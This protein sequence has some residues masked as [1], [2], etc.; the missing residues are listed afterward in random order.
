MTL[1]KKRPDVNYILINAFLTSAYFISAKLGLL[2]AV[3]VEQ[4]TLFWPP[5]GISLAFLLIFG[6]KYWPGFFIGAFFANVLTS[7]P[8]GV[9]LIIAIGNTLEALVG[10]YLLERFN[11]NKSFV[12]LTDFIRFII[13]GVIVST[14]IS[15]TVGVT[16][17]WLVGL[18]Q[19]DDIIRIFGIWWLGDAIGDLIFASLILILFSEKKLFWSF[20]KGIEF[21]LIIIATT[22]ISIL[23]FLSQSII[24]ILFPFFVLGAIRFKKLGSVALALIISV[25]SVWGTFFQQSGPFYIP[26]NLELSLLHL[27]LFVGIV[28]ATYLGLAI[29]IQENAEARDRLQD[30]NTDLRKF[31]LAVAYAS[32]HI[33]ITDADGKILYA[34]RAAVKTTGYST[35]E[36]LGKNPSLWGG[37]MPD[38]F[39]EKMW[40]VIKNNKKT[41]RAEVINKRKNGILYSSAIGISPV[42]DSIGNIAFYVG[43]ERDIT[44]EKEIDRMKTEFISLASHQLRT[45]LGI[46][47]WYLEMLL[48]GDYGKIP[49]RIR[50]VVHDIYKVNNRLITLVNNLLSVSRIQEGKPLNKPTETN[51]INLIKE[52]ISRIKPE[53][54]KYGLQMRL[55]LHKSKVKFPLIKIDA[56]K[57]ANVLMNLLSNAVKYNV[58]NGSVDVYAGIAGKMIKIVIKDT[59]VG[60]QNKD[61]EKIFQ[62]FYRTEDATNMRSDGSGLG[63]FVSKS[64]IDAWGGRI[65]FKSHHKRGTTFY[66]Y[67]PFQPKKV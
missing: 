36:M 49:I 21:I 9:A 63:L 57:L 60:I 58:I 54:D 19:T 43:I 27:Q 59:G 1:F 8:V 23:V 25:V 41:F 37:Q 15:S 46:N 28:T 56:T 14:V 12:S 62:K 20:E 52:E 64:Y 35:K 33:I 53:A 40:N 34:N 11:F 55:H 39:Y 50:R 38:K 17:L 47:R 67:L 29:A 6:K 13:L 7:E 18:I 48:Y 24:Y 31:K 42:L 3:S 22:L 66:I 16:S 4:V 65:Y 30:L 26:G 5:V 51:V 45:P 32:D 61:K 10:T 44:R 2:F